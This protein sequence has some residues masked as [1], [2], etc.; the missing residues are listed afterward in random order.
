MSKAYAIILLILGITGQASSCLLDDR[1]ISLIMQSA[2]LLQG[3]VT[4]Y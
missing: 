4:L 2:M 3:H 1:S